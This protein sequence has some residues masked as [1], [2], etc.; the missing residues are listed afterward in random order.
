MPSPSPIPIISIVTLLAPSISAI[1]TIS[2]F[3]LAPIEVLPVPWTQTSTPAPAPPISPVPT[4]QLPPQILPNH[5]NMHKIAITASITIILLV[6]AAG[7]LA[8]ISHRRKICYN[9]ST[10]VKPPL[11][12]LE[13]GSSLVLLPKLNVN[14]ANHV[15]GEIITDVK[16]LDVTE[17]SKF[18]VNIFIEILEVFL[19]LVGIN[20]LALSINTG[21]DHVGALVHVG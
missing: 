5:L 13:C 1:V 9:R 18:L 2:R 12:R 6:L 17:L 20:G 4:V 15:V 7:G 19:N 10:R 21:G 16:V 3:S 11:Q 8:E 14:I